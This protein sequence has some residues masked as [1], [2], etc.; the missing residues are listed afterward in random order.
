MPYW[1]GRR[2]VVTGGCGMI[3]APLVRLLVE[4]GA[5]VIVLDDLSRGYTQIEGASYL[6]GDAGSMTRCV[7]TFQRAD[8]VFN[9]AAT[10]AGVDYNM[11]HQ[12]AM[13]SANMRL[14]LVPVLAAVEARVRR[15]VQC[16]SACIYSPE[17]NHPAK[18]DYGHA[19][20]P[21]AG[22]AGYAW[23]KRMGERAFLWSGLNGVI[24]RPFNSYGPLDY[25]DERAHVIPALIKKCLQDDVVKVA[26]RDTVREFIYSADVAEGMV[27]AYQWGRN[28]G[29]YNL[30]TGGKTAVKI[31][32]LTMMILNIMGLKDSPPVE[33]LDSRAGDEIRFSDCT[34][35]EKE[36]NWHYRTGLVEG[37]GKAITWYQEARENVGL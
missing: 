29:I 17:Y 22:N 3:G 16:S 21:H 10:V 20:N 9:L 31:R 19:G 5:T 11:A 14:Q 30:G 12:L 35:A 37:L 27:A 28:Q 33:W 6:R 24:V 15:F 18:E 7:E 32:G 25:Y 2:I 26:S 1:N 13:Y 4:H 34:L 36:L 23:A 8:G